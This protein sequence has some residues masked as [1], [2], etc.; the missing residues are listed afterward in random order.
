MPMPLPMS[1][2]VSVLPVPAGPCGAP[3]MINESACE[4]DLAPVSQRCD[5]EA[6]A[7]AELL[8]GVLLHPVGHARVNCAAVVIFF[9]IRDFEAELTLP[10][11]GADLLDV[12][13][14]EVFEHVAFVHLDRDDRDCF[15]L[16]RFPV[17]FG[18]THRPVNDL[19]DHV[20]EFLLV[21]AQT[22]RMPHRSLLEFVEGL[23]A[24]GG[25][26][27]LVH[28]QRQLHDLV[29]DPLFDAEVLLLAHVVTVSVDF[30]LEHCLHV[31][32]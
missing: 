6:F 26:V 28:E 25:P 5:D 20:F 22:L 29:V 2:V 30:R 24:L 17:V 1:L 23:G 16:E 12:L 21:E 8:V 27:D 31:R 32:F 9:F 10:C 18:E 7:V 14:D 15:A 13:L 19:V 3:P 11:E 4:G